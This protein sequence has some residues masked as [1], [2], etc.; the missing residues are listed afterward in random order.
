MRCVTELR[1]RIATRRNT[2]PDNRRSSSRPSPRF[3]PR[4]EVLEDRCLPST[5]T[6]TS[7][8]D[9]G[10]KGTLR[11]DLAQAASG[12]TIKISP[13]IHGP[14]V[15]TQGEL[16][17]NTDVTIEAN[18]NHP[19][20]ISGNNNS[21]VFEIASRANV[22]LMNL[23]LTGGNGVA[24]NPTGTSLYNGEGGSVLNFGKLT[25]DNGT[26][27]NSSATYGG[28]LLSF[29]T[30]TMSNSTVSGNSAGSGGGIFNDGTMT[31]SNSTVSNNSATYLGGGIE[32]G[33]D[34][35]L[36]VSNSTLSDNTAGWGGGI[37]N[38]SY[39]TATVSG[40]TL[41]GNS[42]G[43]G[44]AIYNYNYGTM[45]VDGSTLS[46]NTAT[47]SEGAIYNDFFALLYLNNDTFSGNSP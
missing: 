4:L 46:D 45:T 15:L 35:T 1:Q 2:R 9:D 13:G 17:V 32:N 20:T 29:G 24:I 23:T 31:I 22:T 30:L 10:S 37:Y 6:V 44:G 18:A 19:A 43:Y 11:Y 27:S 40:S 33:G 3:R 21:R 39:G 12:D 36:T 38:Y 25:V 28:G 34:S 41:S 47:Y 14:I 26:V 16:L 8:A 42:A 5:L 7:A